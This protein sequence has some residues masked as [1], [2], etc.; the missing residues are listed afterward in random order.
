MKRDI[1][2][3]ILGVII[4]ALV[5]VFFQNPL[6]VLLNPPQPIFVA[7][8]NNEFCPDRLSF[9]DGIA[10]FIVYYKNASN[11]AGLF[12]VN[13]RADNNLLS[14]YKTPLGDYDKNSSKEWYVEGQNSQQF[15]FNLKGTPRDYPQNFTVELLLVCKRQFG[16]LLLPCGELDK[17]CRYA[18]E[19]SDYEY[20]MGSSYLLAGNNCEVK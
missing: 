6:Q 17:C 7:N 15:S 14:K 13:L 2:L 9:D 4:A 10:D 5:Y 16:S 11:S 12:S 8:Y 3:L 19:S 18:L 20:G 1:K